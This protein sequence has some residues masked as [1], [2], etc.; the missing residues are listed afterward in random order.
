MGQRLYLSGVSDSKTID[1]SVC[2]MGRVLLS[3]F[4]SSLSLKRELRKETNKFAVFFKCM[5]DG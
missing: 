2:V 1:V 4:R 5:V 3:A